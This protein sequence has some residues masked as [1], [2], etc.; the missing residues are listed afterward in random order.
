MITGNEG[1]GFQRQEK[2]SCKMPITKGKTL[3]MRWFFCHKLRIFLIGHLF[4]FLSHFLVTQLRKFF[5]LLSFLLSLLWHLNPFS[6]HCFI[7]SQNSCGH[8]T[9]LEIHLDYFFSQVLADLIVKDDKI[10]NHNKIS[11]MLLFLIKYS[12]FL[13][14]SVSV[15]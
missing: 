13:L 11:K 10:P 2:H 9:M 14:H 15:N 3:Q 1:A 8:K 5:H 7:F 6:L 4:R 12:V